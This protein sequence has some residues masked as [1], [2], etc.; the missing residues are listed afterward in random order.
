MDRSPRSRFLPRGWGLGGNSPPPVRNPELEVL[1]QQFLAEIPARTAVAQDIAGSQGE[2][3]KITAKN[4][5]IAAA[6]FMQQ[7]KRALML[8]IQALIEK[9]L[10][11]S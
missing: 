11:A 5:K 7:E 10:A 2:L 8:K 6:E 1:T 9:L 3:A 4:R